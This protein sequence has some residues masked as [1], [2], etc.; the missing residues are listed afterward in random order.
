MERTYLLINST[1]NLV[2]IVEQILD[3][4]F[5][6]M[7]LDRDIGGSFLFTDVVAVFLI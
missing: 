7:D 3:I 2:V 6:S 5:V 4:N 1:D